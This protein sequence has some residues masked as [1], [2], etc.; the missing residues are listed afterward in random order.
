MNSRMVALREELLLFGVLLGPGRLGR[1]FR[2]I[3]HR[4]P[5]DPG[6]TGIAPPARAPEPR[7]I[8]EDHLGLARELDGKVHGRLLYRGHF[9]HD[10][11]LSRRQKSR[12]GFPALRASQV[13]LKSKNDAGL[14]PDTGRASAMTGTV[15]LKLD[16]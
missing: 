8:F 1:D 10:Y 16:R 7:H 14:H 11:I 5:G 3:S 2:R 9:A 6:A 13:M 15:F 12:S 4:R